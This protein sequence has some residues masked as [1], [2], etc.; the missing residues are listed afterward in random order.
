LSAAGP[1]LT[2]ASR[3]AAQMRKKRA[4]VKRQSHL[5]QAADA[6]FSSIPSSR[7][8]VASIA[9]NSSA[10][11]SSIDLSKQRGS[12]DVGSAAS[13]AGK[14]ESR[15]ALLRSSAVFETARI[16]SFQP[17]A[18]GVSFPPATS[19]GAK[20]R[21]P[22]SRS[23]VHQRRASLSKTGKKS[24]SPGSKK[25]ETSPTSARSQVTPALF[26]EPAVYKDP[27][28]V[29]K[30]EPLKRRPGPIV[31]FKLHVLGH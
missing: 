3:L 30:V 22:N 16:A 28:S 26:P 4:A 14:S 1:I 27:L 9:S 29:Y 8:S 23:C 15:K 17:A 24:P 19:E 7:T 10:L 31:S 13:M 6:A 5:L 20:A 12:P 18:F 25:A 2:L 21:T 11:A